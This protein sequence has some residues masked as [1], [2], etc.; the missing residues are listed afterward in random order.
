MFCRQ[1]SHQ[2]DLCMDTA[3][4]KRAA[5]KICNTQASGRRRSTTD[6][7]I[8]IVYKS[9]RTLY[10]H[11]YIT[12]RYM[13][14]MWKSSNRDLSELAEMRHS[15]IWN[16]KNDCDVETPKLFHCFQHNALAIPRTTYW[17]RFSTNV[18]FHQ[19]IWKIFVACAKKYN[20][21]GSQGNQNN[22][23]G[24]NV[25]TELCIE[26]LLHS[27]NIFLLLIPDLLW[28]VLRSCCHNNVSDRS[29][30]LESFIKMT[31]TKPW[32]R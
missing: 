32:N 25:V 17:N 8:G 28:K 3:V 21:A 24:I 29:T 26:T 4:A 22:V 2:N 10:C 20:V 18:R 13:D 5:A 16:I 12:T 11:Q 7:V 15:T 30:N 1:P 27:F 19:T 23:E 9:V 31:C 6:E 14:R